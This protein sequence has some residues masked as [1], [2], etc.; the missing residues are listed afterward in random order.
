[1]ARE[2]RKVFYENVY[3]FLQLE[4]SPYNS[5]LFKVNNVR[6]VMTKYACKHREVIE[7]V[8]QLGLKRLVPHPYAKA[9]EHISS[10]NIQFGCVYL[11]IY[12][13]IS[14]TY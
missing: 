12:F 2:L 8:H 13:L 4:D 10:C 9:P 7:V 6:H 3:V 11:G 1:M 14:V 5:Y